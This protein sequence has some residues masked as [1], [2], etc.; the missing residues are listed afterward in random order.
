[1]SA[2]NKRLR[3]LQIS[4][5][6]VI[7]NTARAITQS[8]RENDKTIPENHTH[9][10]TFSIRSASS[11]KEGDYD[12]GVEGTLDDS[13]QTWLKRVQVRLHDTYKDNN[14]T[15]D[16]PPFVVSE[17]G[18]GE[19]ELV[20]RLHF[21]PESGERPL[22]LHHMLKL[23]P[24]N[25]TKSIPR[26]DGLPPTVHSWQYDEIVFNDPYE[27]FYNLLIANPPAELPDDGVVTKQARDEESKKLNAVKKE[28]V[29]STTKL[30][31]ELI[32][33]EN[34]LKNIK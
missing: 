29:Q 4:R 26:D 23:H 1:M 31:N 20:I 19:F 10:W 16:K 6:F 33:M 9:R 13:L 22:T 27:S 11:D 7:G 24:W 25:V 14:K 3:G 15:L 28:V 2:A 30:R 18:W 17:T 12:D 8:E 21:S 34:E 5:P 32:K